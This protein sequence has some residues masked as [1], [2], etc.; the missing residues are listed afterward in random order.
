[1]RRDE[2]DGRAGVLARLRH[3]AE[4]RESARLPSAVAHWAGLAI[5]AAIV[6]VVIVVLIWAS[7]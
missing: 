6:V 3:D 1:M 2:R 7:P 4:R 5:I